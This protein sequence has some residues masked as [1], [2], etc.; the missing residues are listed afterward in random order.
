LIISPL[1]FQFGYFLL[2]F[3]ASLLWLGLSILCRI[4]VV[5]V[6][7]F[8]LL[9]TLAGQL[10]AFLHWV[11]YWLWVCHKRL[12]WCWKSSVY[13]HV[14]CHEWMLNFVKCFFC[15]YWDDHLLFLLIWC[16]ILIDLHVLNDPYELGMNPTWLWYMIFFCVVGFSLLE[17][18]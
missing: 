1:L 17:F 6:G 15:K 13:N 16:I 5:R 12:L 8:D 9:Q 11:L 14:G 4:E 18:C 10:S 2:L 3:L 7:I